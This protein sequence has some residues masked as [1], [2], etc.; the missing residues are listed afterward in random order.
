MAAADLA[1]VAPA[2]T[3]AR[4]VCDGDAAN[5]QKIDAVRQLVLVGD[6]LDDEDAR[7]AAG[8]DKAK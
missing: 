3:V 7:V 2:S 5:Q 1:A 4:P 8:I 6:A